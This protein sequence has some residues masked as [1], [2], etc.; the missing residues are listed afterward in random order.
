MIKKRILSLS[1]KFLAFSLQVNMVQRSARHSGSTSSSCWCPCGEPSHYSPSPRTDRWLAA[2]M[3]AWADCR[4]WC[5]FGK[6]PT[7]PL[8]AR[9][10]NTGCNTAQSSWKG[11]RAWKLTKGSQTKHLLFRGSCTLL[12]IL[13]KLQPAMILRTGKSDHIQFKGV[14]AKYK[15]GSLLDIFCVV[16][17]H[18]LLQD[19]SCCCCSFENFPRKLRRFVNT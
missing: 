4:F 13:H 18:V 9:G 10:I 7:H 8:L 2:T 3:W 15:P 14:T 16:V 19:S 11:R 17:V 6:A 5:W 12:H 1:S